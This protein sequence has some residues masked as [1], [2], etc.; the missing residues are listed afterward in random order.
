MK[1]RPKI[2]RQQKY[3]RDVGLQSSQP[4]T[5]PVAGLKGPLQ[6]RALLKTGNTS[7]SPQKG[8]SKGWLVCASS[9]PSA[10]LPERI[11]IVEASPEMSKSPL[12]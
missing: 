10:L 6:Q 12:D 9:A 5:D 7:F 8:T 4:H 11:P 3:E 2:H 1:A